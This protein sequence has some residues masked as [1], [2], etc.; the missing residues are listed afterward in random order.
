MYC[1]LISS[2]ALWT[3]YQVRKTAMREVKLLKQC[4]HP[5]IVDLIE[6]FRRKQILY[7]VFDYVER[8]VLEV[9]AVTLTTHACYRHLVAA[10]EAGG[11]ERGEDASLLAPPRPSPWTRINRRG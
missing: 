9:G 2:L 8:T 7:L 6:V 3:L 1:E 5:N 4:K 10:A 11:G